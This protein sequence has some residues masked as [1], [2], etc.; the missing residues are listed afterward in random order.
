MKKVVPTVSIDTKQKVKYF[1]LCS[2]FQKMKDDNKTLFFIY[3]LLTLPGYFSLEF[4][5]DMTLNI[6]EH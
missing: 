3:F 6:I 1:L 2:W 5:G 4:D